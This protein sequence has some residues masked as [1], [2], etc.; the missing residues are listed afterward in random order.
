M[1]RLEQRARILFDGGASVMVAEELLAYTQPPDHGT[2]R[3]PSHL[4]LPGELSVDAWRAYADEAVD[5]GVFPALRKRLVQLQFPIQEGMSQTDTYQAATRGGQDVSGSDA[6]GVILEQPDALRLLLHQTAAGTIPV[7]VAQGRHDFEALVQAFAKKN[8]PEP[9]P[10]SMGACIIIGYSNWDR[11][12]KLRHEWEATTGYPSMFASIY[13]NQELRDR[14]LP[15]KPLYQDSFIVLSDGDYSGVT[16]EDMDLPA[17]VW[18]RDSLLIRLEHECTHYLMRRLLPTRPSPIVEELIADLGGMVAA[19]GRYDA[20][21]FL[22]FVGLETFPHYRAGARLD[23]YR[24]TPPLSEEAFAILIR[25]VRAAAVNLEQ[26]YNRQA[27]RWAINEE[28][29]KLVLALSCLALEELASLRCDQ[30]VEQA[31]RS[32]E[33][34]G[35]GLQPGSRRVTLAS[36]DD[37]VAHSYH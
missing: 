19:W 13:W 18:R 2:V 7:I 23:L 25:L 5:I 8:E 27:S 32:I 26:I 15:Y 16:A 34:G 29:V 35:A 14:I 30:Y 24:G 11:I 37:Q 6:V 10:A 17:D 1:N 31:L 36:Q 21:R 3:L 9:I 22:R 33:A 28:Y 12:R 4:P 20:D